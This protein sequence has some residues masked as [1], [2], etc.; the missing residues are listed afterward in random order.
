MI[1]TFMNQTK[2]GAARGHCRELGCNK[3]TKKKKEG[4]DLGEAYFYAT[5]RSAPFLY[6][7]VAAMASV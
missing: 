3:Q 4:A 7:V 5:P 6:C 1:C 2:F